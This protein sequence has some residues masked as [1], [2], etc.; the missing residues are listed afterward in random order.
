MNF[1]I[2]NYIVRPMKEFGSDFHLITEYQSGS[3]HLPDLY[4]NGV[5]LADGRQ[6]I[7]ALIRQEGWRRLWMPEYFCYRVIRYIKQQTGIDVVSYPDSPL[8][9]DKSI[10][11][12]LR[13]ED[14]DALL[15]M[16]YF[17]MR[18]LRSEADIP[19]PVIEDHT[20]NLSGCWSLHSDADWCIAS[21]RKTMPLPEGG[22]LWSPKGHQFSA[23]IVRS[24]TNQQMAEKR[25]Q[26]MQMKHDYLNGA[27]LDKEAFRMLYLETEEWFDTAELSLIDDRSR[28]YLGQL[29]I[30]AWHSAKRRN[31]QLL[32]SLISDKVQVL[33]PEKESCAMFSLVLL[34]DSHEQ[35]D[36]LRLKLIK[37][38]V[39]PAILWNV[40]DNVSKE[41]RDFSQR[42]LSI[43]CD[44]RYNENDIRQLVDIVNQAIES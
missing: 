43:H 18:E 6:G 26:A 22:M 36:R 9:N 19:V 32:C 15:R 12:K 40:P 25:W 24:E 38:S 44:G 21:L 28:D 39:Y 4:P 7:V 10:V 2:R 8:E 34:T 1:S 37:R 31:W 5:L 41:T 42:M 13:F 35:R 29:D 14:G 33:Q 3:V 27:S 16:N 23:Q 30:H 17:G 11:K 20:H